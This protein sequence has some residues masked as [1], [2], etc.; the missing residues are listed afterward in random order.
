MAKIVTGHRGVD[1]IT[2][3]DVSSFQQGIVGTQDYLLSDNPDEFKAVIGTNNTISL[4]DADIVIQG[5]HARIFSTDTVRIE[6]GT[7]GVTRIDSIIARYTRDESGVENV[8]VLVKTGTTSPPKL[9]QT[10]IRGAGTVREVALWNVTLNG[11]VAN[12]P[13]RVIPDIKSLETLQNAIKTLQNEVNSAS[14]INATQNKD[15]ATVKADIKSMNIAI[16]AL[17]SNKTFD[18]RIYIKDVKTTADNIAYGS[19]NSYE[20][21]YRKKSSGATII[22]AIRLEVH[23]KNNKMEA[24]LAL[25]SDGHMVLFIGD[26]A[27][28]IPFVQ[29]GSILIKPKTKVTE[30]VGSVT[31]DKLTDKITVDKK[32]Y[33]VTILSKTY[34][35]TRTFY[36]NTVTVTF[37]KPYT[38]IPRVAITP[39]STA[40]HNIHWGITDIT[41]KGFKIYLERNSIVETT[42]DW[43][44]FGSITI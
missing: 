30:T 37:E 33:T 39:H 13:V 32:S 10:D 23:N 31:T 44:A 40:G 7:S 16:N 36:E 17:K 22:N 42:F 6:Q 19:V 27:Y 5:T 26:K 20:S 12:E 21:E 3:D 25:Y 41:T 18:D 34:N 43:I 14:N 1:H 9:E 24:G 8:D 38:S 11:N 29:K 28:S 2:S 35:V 15:I 4:C